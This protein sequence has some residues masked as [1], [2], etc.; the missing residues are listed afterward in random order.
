M[1]G[2]FPAP[3]YPYITPP[4]WD[5]G[6]SLLDRPSASL[7]DEA[8]D[9][10]RPLV[11]LVKGAKR[12]GKSTFGR[13]AMNRL[14]E[15]Y[16]RVAWLECD[17][18]QGEFSCGGVVGIW[19]LDRPVLGEPFLHPLLDGSDMIRPILHAL[20]HPTAST[21]PRYLLPSNLSR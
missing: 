11:T 4:S 5:A 19:V 12:S 15:R 2:S 16:E 3:V 14:L 7:E 21:L 17:L 9:T 8:S 6:L 20:G 13:A 1:V 18:G 10:L